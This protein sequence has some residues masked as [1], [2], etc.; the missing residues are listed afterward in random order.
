MTDRT[1]PAEKTL[2][3]L[4]TH[5]VTA[6]HMD[7][8]EQSYTSRGEAFFHVSGAGHEGTVALYPYLTEN[9]WLH[10]HYRDKALMLA[11]GI[12]PMMFFLSLFNKD[13]SHSRGRQM[14]AH[15]SAPALKVLSI[16]GPVG[17]SA[18]Q[19]VGVA[20]VIRDQ[21]GSPLVLCALG[22]G[23][24]QEGEVIEAIGHAVRV[25]APVL[26]VIQDNAFAISTRTRGQ[27][28]YSRPEGEAESFYGV[29]IT[30]IDGR[31]AAA[32]LGA[33]GPVVESIRLERKPRI[34]VFSVERLHNHTNA[35]DQRLYRTS[36][37]IAAAAASG[38]PLLTL[39]KQLLAAGFSPEELDREE[40]DI[41]ARLRE[42]ARQ[43]QAMPE[44]EP[45]R[46]AKAPLPEHLLNRQ[47][48][49]RGSG[50]TE[51]VMLEAIRDVLDY[52]MGKD[53]RVT[54]FGEDLEDP[55]GDVF[56]I[57]RGLTRKYGARV[58][59]S[60]LSESL[61]LGVSVGR[62]LA[63]G[64]P[65]AFLQFA[66][67]L[68]IAYNQIF[69]EL[70][71]MYWRTDGGWKVPVIVMVTAGGYR[72]GLGPFHAS[73]LE[74]LV[75]HTPGV[76]VFM[77]STAGDAAGLLNAAFES[78]RPTVFF[79]PKNQLN[80][81]SA[82][83][84]RDVERQLVPVGKARYAR[85]GEDITIVAYG[86]TVPLAEKA[87]ADLEKAGATAEV[88]DLRSI[89]PW[90]IELVLESVGRT[91]RLIVAHED[92]HTAGFGAEVIS[93]VAERS[94]KSI[95]ARRVTR[96]DTYVPCNF[97][98]QL[99]I[100][101]SYKRILD[102]A[103][104]LLGGTIVWKQTDSAL[105]GLFDVEAVGSSPSDESVTM[106]EWRVAP[107]D[108][109]QEGD[110]LAEVEA[111]KAAAELT[112]PVA[113][114]VRE[115]FMQQ[116]DT[117]P[118]G[119]PIVRI[120]TATDGP[121]HVK[122]QTREMP[123]EPIITDLGTGRRES[124]AEAPESTLPAP[125][126]GSGTGK[127]PEPMPVTAPVCLIAGVA[128][129]RGSRIVGNGELAALSP[130]WDAEDIRKR[131]GIES[132]PWIGD[133]ENVLSLAVD[134]ARQVLRETEID[135]KSINQIIFATGTPSSTTPSMAALLQYELA[136]EAGAFQCT[137]FDINA[138]CSG[139]IY[140]LQL[141]WDYLVSSPAH[142]V[143]L[144]TSE[145]LSTRLDMHDAGT[146]PIFGDAA[147]ATILAGARALP[148]GGASAEVYRPVTSAHGESGA[149]LCV[150]QE[151][152]LPVTMDGPKVYQEAVKAM[153]ST[154]S[155]S[156]EA[157]G[158]RPE[159]LDLY[160]PHQANQRIINAIR[161]RMKLP[162]EKMYSNIRGNGNTSSSTIP[163]CLAEL[164]PARESN[165][166]WGL[167]AFGGGFT[168]GAALL[169]TR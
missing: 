86:N 16:V 111:D 124:T 94:Q 83:T 140:G 132:R 10:C 54:L 121:A 89:V 25:G 95:A 88:I 81:R 50:E 45:F 39:K 166:I 93:T 58:K 163:L 31:N 97:G 66:D 117:V 141:A 30:R 55:K 109:V 78:E 122:T 106:V 154:L 36:E 35:D 3:A 142:R 84:S 26:F 28:F 110:L 32:A 80:D 169:R 90:D 11:R 75:A 17:N 102:T 85:R 156:A 77:P 162:E 134:A 101:P 22:E 143:L 130:D 51:L 107:G 100:L 20:E 145:V 148:S 29:P 115:L 168:Y 68:P 152:E 15:M 42:E 119:T 135:A 76:D 79:Y 43:A 4:Y 105:T 123:G 61:I 60:P 138:A 91:G 104:D 139:Y 129:R 6:R 1:S 159:S 53:D 19:A 155:S 98:N 147:T 23:M 92:N 71:S 158:L 116:G 128:A 72:P 99:E 8:I 125:A 38:D 73:T 136:R 149:T 112:S 46:D 153:M 87:A 167:T 151:S 133:G 47:G 118:V 52:R 18:L 96:P 126:P 144:I 74:A 164:L 69:S 41:I 48:E 70:G 33:F 127:L 12:T 5:M 65:V 103:V 34:V 157:A 82:A 57:T 59:N 131:T 24:T 44:P 161:Q 146:A 165:R 2:R 64:R 27:T 67:F 40:E 37:E 120:A 9:D 49:Y 13:A 113:G 137:A 108:T 56:G 63:G 114:T 160:I 21:P 7:L 62:A 14:N 150:P